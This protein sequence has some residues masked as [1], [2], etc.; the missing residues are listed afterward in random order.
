MDDRNRSN[1]PD[2]ACAQ[3]GSEPAPRDTPAADAPCRSRDDVKQWRDELSSQ[4]KAVT[5]CFH[6]PELSDGM[7]AAFRIMGIDPP[8]P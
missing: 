4:R 5:S 3:Q 2:A 7:A 8:L 6:G 1:S